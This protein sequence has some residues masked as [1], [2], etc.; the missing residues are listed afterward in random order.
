LTSPRGMSTAWFC[1]A[2]LLSPDCAGRRAAC[3]YVPVKLLAALR[4]ELEGYINIAARNAI[5]ALVER[6]DDDQLQ[7][8]ST[9]ADG[10]RRSNWGRSCRRTIHA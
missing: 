6:S 3:A 8:D 10:S 7:T 2:E 4:L 9:R 5:L 1:D